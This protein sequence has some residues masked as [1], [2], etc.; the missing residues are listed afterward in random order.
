MPSGFFRIFSALFLSLIFCTSSNAQVQEKRSP[1]SLLWEVTKDGMRAPSYLFGTFHLLNDGFL[2]SW[3]GVGRAFNEC[4]A[5]VVETVIDSSE[6][7]LVMNASL[8]KD[9]LLTD[10]FDS[11]QYNQVSRV[12]EESTGMPMAFFNDRKPI[13]VGV[14]LTLY[15]NQEL[16]ANM[17]PDE[18]VPM[19]IYFAL[20]AK[21]SSISLL[22]LESMQEQAN[23]LYNQTSNSKQAK[24]LLALIQD[25]DDANTL[26]KQLLHAY[27]ANDLNR[28]EKLSEQDYDNWGSMDHLLDDRNKKWLTVIPEVIERQP[29]FIA[30]G[31]LHLVGDTGLIS[32]L[33]AAGFT[34]RPISVN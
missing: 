20:E 25:Q 2:K 9:T 26:S 7:A 18:G 34:L 19:D 33:K 22:P 15:E 21:K 28:L 12:F 5:L 13:F 27:R 11:I 8:M 17:D 29:T 3:P 10:L 23:L 1:T 32:G 30:V 14:M 24:E 4:E 16:L 6:I 31:A